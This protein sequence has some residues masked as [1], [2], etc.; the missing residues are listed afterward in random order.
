MMNS[1]F[2]LGEFATTVPLAADKNYTRQEQDKRPE[3]TGQMI[4][5]L[6]WMDCPGW[7]ARNGL[8]IAHSV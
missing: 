3:R 5:G 1:K 4:D 8:P 6:P 2:A 7:T